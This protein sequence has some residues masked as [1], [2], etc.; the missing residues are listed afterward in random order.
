MVEIHF[1]TDI[2]TDLPIDYSYHENRY[3]FRLS[4]SEIRDYLAHRQVWEDF[5]QTG[6]PCCW[7]IESNVQLQISTN[8]LIET[9]T[10]F[11][12]NQDADLFFPY[13]GEI[14]KI[15]GTT[16]LN[17][18]EIEIRKHEPYLLGYKWGNSIYCLTR[19]GA[20]ALLEISTIQDRLDNIWADMA[21][22]E[23]LHTYF[24]TVKWFHKRYDI[25]QTEWPERI[26]NMAQ[27]VLSHCSWTEERKRKVRLLLRTLSE[28]SQSSGIPL[29]LQAGTHLGY[30]RMGGI[31]PWDDDVD[32]GIEEKHVATF[33]ELLT[34]YTG[35]K[36]R[37][38]LEVASNTYYYKIWLENG[39][40]IEG[41]D[42][43]FPFIDLWMY[44]VTGNDFVFWNG[45]TCPHSALYPLEKIVFE[46]FQF[47]MVGNTEEVLDSR[48]VDW[49]TMI[50]I[51]PWNHRLEKVATPWYDYPM[52]LLNY[53]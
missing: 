15:N 14:E 28:L 7:V 5:L 11:S 50:R 37:K 16:L 52:S 32:L 39:E 20:I 38:I 1:P 13:E 47:Q 51:Y 41:H 23:K 8:K 18:N 42:Y 34:S 45:M 43:T 6:K 31:L 3:G 4:D 30:V 40:S 36:Y 44:N 2:K 53:M 21:F 33:L 12:C 17:F 26:Q 10:E 35:I 48:Y 27:F 19:K 9:A 22:T 25:D 29:I 46:G 24:S 49:R